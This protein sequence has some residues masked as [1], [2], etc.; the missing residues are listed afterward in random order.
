MRLFYKI[1][2]FYLRRVIIIKSIRFINAKESLSNNFTKMKLLHLQ[3]SSIC[4]KFL[5][6]KN[7]FFWSSFEEKTNSFLFLREIFFI[8]F[9]P[10]L[11]KLIISSQVTEKE[12]KVFENT[13]RFIRFMKTQME[14]YKKI[15]TNIKEEADFSNTHLKLEKILPRGSYH[16]YPM[17]MIV[18]YMKVKEQRDFAIRA[19]LFYFFF[20]AYFQAFRF[21]KLL[22]KMEKTKKEKK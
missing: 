19:C 1:N 10:S 14:F 8:R 7:V 4:D 12:K 15:K 20:F 6:L 16:L 9:H 11:H 17:L 18:N 2:S 5:R 22:L 3:I 21:S 13:F